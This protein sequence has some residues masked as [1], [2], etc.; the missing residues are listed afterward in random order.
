[1]TDMSRASHPALA[2]VARWVT[3]VGGAW[4]IAMAAAPA[5]ALAQG[6]YTCAD[7]QGRRL[8]SDRP[9]AACLDREQRE[10]NRNGSLK[11]VLPP[12]Y[13]VV[14]REE[15]E[16]K[17]RQAQAERQRAQDE[18]RRDQALLTRYP[19]RSA[20]DAARRAALA[21]PDG[22]I[23]AAQR[24]I[25]ELNQERRTLDEEMEFY[26]KD[27]SRAPASVRRRIEEMAQLLEVQQRAIATQQ[28]ERGKINARF[29]DELARLQKLWVAA[30][31]PSRAQP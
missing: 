17:Q 24:Q 6:I 21:Q 30:P 19:N 20:H 3:G 1:M 9:I 31:A 7:A 28:S 12:S 14:E 27:P 13:S 23:G 10:L 5:L 2:P 29:D 26:R 18:I 16:A 15:Q 11:R 22:V 8:S 25:A 4:L